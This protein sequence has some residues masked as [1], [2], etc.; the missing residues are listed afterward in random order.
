MW[1]LME[2]IIEKDDI[3]ALTNFL[4]NSDR[5]TNG[6]KVKEFEDRW[7]EWLNINHSVMVNSGASGNFL[8]IALVKELFGIGEIIVPS[9]GWS[10]DVSSIVQLGMTPVFVDVD[11]VTLG[12]NPVSLKNALTEK[13]KAVVIVHALG[14]NAITDEVKQILDEANIFVIED[15]CESHGALLSPISGDRIGT[16]GDVSIFSFYFGHHITT[17]EGGIVSTNNEKLFQLSRMLRSHG[18][19]RE[20]S[21][22]V[23]AQYAASHP[24]LN[25][26]FT[27]AL[28][29]FNFRSTELNAVMGLS[30][31]KKLDDNILTRSKNLDIWLDNL[32]AKKFKIDYQRI[33]NSNFALPLVLNAADNDLKN[34][35]CEKLN[36]LKVEYRL[37]TA[38]GGNLSRQPFVQKYPH[39]IVD[40]QKVVNHIHD[41]GLYVGNGVHVREEAIKRLT[42][43]LNLL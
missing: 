40:D 31:M 12:V 8:T 13:T 33:G 42:D 43:E 1:K 41:Y 16:Y 18:M 2:N 9:L 23:R 25:P 28:A 22:E 27:F 19:T 39:R 37:G 3:D 6:P 35:V 14:F 34:R 29:G 24:D 11:P 15:C 20:A 38:G 30:Q 17:I 4:N 21:H 10:S 36:N 32:S 26:L 7:S 5:F